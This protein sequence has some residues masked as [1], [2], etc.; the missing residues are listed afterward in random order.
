MSEAL[1]LII[2]SA[3]LAIHFAMR[4]STPDSETE[5][6]LLSPETSKATA[7]GEMATAPDSGA[8]GLGDV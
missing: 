1:A 4:W 7:G 6:R 3:F 2:F 5:A 8:G